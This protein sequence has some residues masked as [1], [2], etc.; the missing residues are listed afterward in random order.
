MAMKIMAAKADELAPNCQGVYKA[1]EIVS[2]NGDTAI[3]GSAQ[4][5]P[6][7]TAQDDNKHKPWHN[8]DGTLSLT[9]DEVRVS[10]NMH[11]VTLVNVC[12]SNAL[13]SASLNL[14]LTRTP[15]SS[16]LVCEAAQVYVCGRDMCR[17]A[18]HSW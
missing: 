7:A 8:F 14:M 3:W 4:D 1:R 2:C 11:T 10:S 17:S 18:Y 13:R 15:A 6:Q 9:E 12:A 5:G 16:D